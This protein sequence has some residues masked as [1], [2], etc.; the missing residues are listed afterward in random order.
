MGGERSAGNDVG[1]QVIGIGFGYAQH[2]MAVGDEYAVAL[3]HI[4]REAGIWDGDDALGGGD[5]RRGY[6]DARAD[7]EVYAVVR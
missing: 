5:V 1:L 7:L 6:A 2:Q 3:G 4:L